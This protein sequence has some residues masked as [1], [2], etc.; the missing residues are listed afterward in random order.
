[1]APA[2]GRGA[3]KGI[4]EHLD[5]GELVVGD[6]SFLITLEKRGCVKAGLWT[7]EAI[8]GHPD[9]VRQLHVEFLRAGS[10]V[11]QT[12]TF[13][14][15]GDNM[16]SQY[17][18][19]AEEAVWAVEV[20][21]ESRKPMAATM[22]I[23]PEGDMHGIT[24]GE[25]AVKL[26]KAGASVVG[27]NCRFGPWTS[28]KTMRLMKEGLRAGGLKAHL[29]VQSLGFHMPDCSKGGFVD[30]P[31]YPFAL[32]PRVAT[33]WD[34]QNYAREAYDLGVRY[35]GRCCGFEPYHIRAIAEELAPE[36]GFLPPASDKHGSWGSGL[37]T[38][39]KPWMGARARR[40]YWENLLPAS[41][42]P[43]CPSLSKPDA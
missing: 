16:E 36:S 5:S 32:E 24:P 25:C 4:L 39:S 12:F 19:Y 23:G 7:P 34:T 2:G 37:D 20:L 41:G 8:A 33:R 3:K 42:R 40:E 30:L 27:V 21:K 13:S 1:M 10:N 17:F 26:V 18:E 35:I 29:V 38:H 6:G 11:M 22:C 15:S 43:F 14:A 9:A 31:E 28:L